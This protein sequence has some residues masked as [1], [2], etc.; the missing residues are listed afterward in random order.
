M[1][2][3]AT[4][5]PKKRTLTEEAIKRGIQ[6]YVKDV[7]EVLGVVFTMAKTRAVHPKKEARIENAKETNLKV[8][9]LPVPSERRRLASQMFA[10]SK[11]AYG[12]V[13][14]H[15]QCPSNPKTTNIALAVINKRTMPMGNRNLE[16]VL[17]RGVVDPACIVATRVAGIAMRAIGRKNAIWSEC[18]GTLESKLRHILKVLGWKESGGWR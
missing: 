1:N 15:P 2:R 3:W 10:S 18:R 4:D 11:L 5:G 17:E 8:G 13:T 7:A 14:A 9:T 12:W 16:C 6:T